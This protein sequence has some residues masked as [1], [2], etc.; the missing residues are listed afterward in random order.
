ME[1]GIEFLKRQLKYM[2]KMGFNKFSKTKISQEYI[3][4]MLPYCI[5]AFN[6]GYIL[7]NREY[8]PLGVWGYDDMVDYKDYNYATIT[9]NRGVKYFYGDATN[10]NNS[11]FCFD[12]YF[13]NL[14][15]FLSDEQEKYIIDIENEDTRAKEFS[16]AVGEKILF[17][18]KDRFRFIRLA[19]HQQLKIK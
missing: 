18:A 19:E 3:R 15:Y 10:P 4:N 2:E 16:K 1:K 9:D 7:L 8:K 12:K 5:Q 13:L 6:D 11:K 17:I 14:K